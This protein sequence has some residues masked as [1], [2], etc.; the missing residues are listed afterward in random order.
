MALIAFQRRKR[1][2]KGKKKKS[3]SSYSLLKVVSSRTLNHVKVRPSHSA[4]REWTRPGLELYW[5]G[6][7]HWE[8]YYPRLRIIN[9]LRHFPRGNATLAFT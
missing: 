4:V 7:L 6:E 8:I 2:R 1:E 5:E 3:E 9:H